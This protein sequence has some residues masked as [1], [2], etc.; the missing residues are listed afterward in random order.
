MLSISTE[1]I[2]FSKPIV[3]GFTG[4][5]EGLTDWQQINVVFALQC[6]KSSHGTTAVHGDCIGGDEFF[7]K[8][9]AQLGFQTRARP[10]CD[11]KGNSP[12]RAYVDSD[13]IFPLALYLVRNHRIVDDSDIMIAC[14]KS[15][16]EELRSGTWAT[17]RYARRV[18]K[19]VH[20][21]YPEPKK[22]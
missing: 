21:I 7:A 18:G 13:E 4:T 5:Q 2:D 9:T 12:K 19:R 8:V 3:I 1:G 14:P 20:M 10:G 11:S 16:E 6:F 15:F 22:D 17:V